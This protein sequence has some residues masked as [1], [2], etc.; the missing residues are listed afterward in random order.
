MPETPEEKNARISANVARMTAQHAPDSDIE[1]YL[2]DVEGLKAVSHTTA[3]AA[4][5]VPI[6]GVHQ[7]VQK[8]IAAPITD[9]QLGGQPGLG[10]KILGTIAATGRDIPGVEAAQSGV[11]AFLRGEPYAQ[12][13]QEIRG[14]EDAAPM[15]ATLPAR[16]GGAALSTVAGGRLLGLGAKATGALYG[17]LSGALDSNPE[18]SQGNRA[19]ETAGGAAIGGMAGAAGQKVAN[20]GGRIATKAGSALM[21]AIKPL[22]TFGSDLTIPAEAW[23]PPVPIRSVPSSGVADAIKTAKPNVS[24]ALQDLLKRANVGLSPEER[25]GNTMGD[26]DIAQQPDIPPS[27]LGALLRESLTMGKRTPSVG[28]SRGQSLGRP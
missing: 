4:A 27:N 3:P 2:R 28:M 24:A 7:A 17:G 20:V 18:L 11:R 21:D 8:A 22:G 25:V 19:L 5:S 14:A 15:S 16:F 12:A 6:S 26:A 23:R 13:R 9:E 10:T 1:A